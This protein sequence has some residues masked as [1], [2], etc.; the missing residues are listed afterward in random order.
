MFKLFKGSRLNDY[1]QLQLY[2]NNYIGVCIR[3]LGYG[4]DL[5]VQIHDPAR[6]F[7]TKDLNTKDNI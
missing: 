1:L 2:I 3:I 7:K 6:E 5:N 4:F